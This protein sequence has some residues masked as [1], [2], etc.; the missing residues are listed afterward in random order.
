MQNQF[1]ESKINETQSEGSENFAFK[2]VVSNKKI[3][4]TWSVISL[5]CA[6]LSV[7]F[8]WL[9]W[10]GLVFGALSV[11]FALLSRRELSY[12]D[13]IS[14]SSIIIGIFGIVFAIVGIIFGGFLS[15]LWFI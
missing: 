10:L 7:G 12:F 9:S 1:D 4:R 3:R 13:S 15:G 6:I 14:V 8:F 2:N 11:S 5:I